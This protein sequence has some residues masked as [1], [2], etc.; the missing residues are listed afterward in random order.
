MLFET[1]LFNASIVSGIVFI[2]LG[3]YYLKS[4]PGS[5]VRSSTTGIEF[6]EWFTYIY[7]GTFFIIMAT[8]V[9]WFTP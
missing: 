4:D 9:I 8:I 2:V 7:T 3:L 5:W 1:W 6:P